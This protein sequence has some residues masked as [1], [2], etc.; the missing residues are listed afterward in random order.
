MECSGAFALQFDHDG[1][2][3][4]FSIGDAFLHNLHV[5]GGFTGLAGTLAID[6]V[7]SDEDEGVGEEVEGEGEAASFLPHLEFVAIEVGGTLL[8]DGHSY[9]G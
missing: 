4:F 8:E 6:A 5:H 7:L 1:S 9:I 3:Q 2:N